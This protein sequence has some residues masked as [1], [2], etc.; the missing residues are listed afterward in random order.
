M[1]GGGRGCLCL[2]NFCQPLLI[3]L[4]YLSH[5]AGV[6]VYDGTCYISGISDLKDILSYN[7]QASDS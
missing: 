6:T 4:E 7:D 5:T 2:V 1:R 3:W